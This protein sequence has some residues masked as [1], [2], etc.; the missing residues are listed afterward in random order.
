MGFGS[1]RFGSFRF[2]SVRVCFGCG[3]FRFVPFVL[4]PFWLRLGCFLVS[5]LFLVARAPL[6]GCVLV[7]LWFR[8]GSHFG[9]GWAGGQRGLAVIQAIDL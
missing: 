9:S 2:A 6:I 3:V 7:P 5:T 4:V 8:V 1:V